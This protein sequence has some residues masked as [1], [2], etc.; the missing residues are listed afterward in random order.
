MHTRTLRSLNSRRWH[1]VSVEWIYGCVFWANHL[2][3]PRQNILLPLYRFP[4]GLWDLAS[5]SITIISCV[6]IQL[7]SWRQHHLF[8]MYIPK[9]YGT[10]LYLLAVG[11]VSIVI[12]AMSAEV[13]YGFQMKHHHC[14][15][16]R[17]IT[18]RI[19]LRVIHHLLW[20]WQAGYRNHKGHLATERQLGRPWP[21]GRWPVGISFYYYSGHRG[22][23]NEQRPLLSGLVVRDLRSDTLTPVTLSPPPPL[24]VRI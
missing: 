1:K 3:G 5:F 24:S 23:S 6:L 2:K 20:N 18:S 17:R 8:Q 9:K 16:Q 21:L 22:L 14:P 13:N 19:P 12:S 10:Y 11:G 15:W 7:T 4:L